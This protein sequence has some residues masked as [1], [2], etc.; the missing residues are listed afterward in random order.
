MRIRPGA[1]HLGHSRS[2]PGYKQTVE[3]QELR[4]AIL[5]MKLMR[6]RANFHALQLESKLKEVREM[7]Q[8]EKREQ[9]ARQAIENAV[10]VSPR[11]R[12]RFSTQGSSSRSFREPVQR[13]S[14]STSE[15]LPE[16]EETSIESVSE[17]KLVMETSIVEVLPPAKTSAVEVPRLVLPQ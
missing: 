8:G 9:Y 3:E 16:Q 4:E 15:V 6:D 13:L 14:T 17:E 12:N 5:E 7:P 11:C 1:P 10:L 2:I